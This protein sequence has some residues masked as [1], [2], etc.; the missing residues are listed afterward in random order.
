VDIWVAYGR[1]ERQV[2]MPL[3]LPEGSTVEQAIRAS[4]ILGQFPEID[5]TKQKVGL[6]GKLAKLEAPLE[7]GARVEIYR[8]IIADPN[9]VKRRDLDEDED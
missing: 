7:D 2:C 9:T 4:G 1:A 6:Y 3:Q 5:L 8:A